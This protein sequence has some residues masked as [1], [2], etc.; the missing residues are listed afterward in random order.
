[1]TSIK[2][3]MLPLFVVVGALLQLGCD[4]PQT[5][6]GQGARIVRFGSGPGLGGQGGNGQTSQ[7]IPIQPYNSNMYAS[8]QAFVSAFM[9]PNSVGTINNSGDVFIIGYIDRNQQGQVNYA[10]SAIRIEIQDSYARSGQDVPISLEIDQLSY[11]V[12]NGN[13][14]QL[15][16]EYQPNNSSASGAN[17]IIIEGEMGQSQFSGLVR[18]SN[19]SSYSSQSNPTSGVL[20]TFQV[21][22]CGFFRCSN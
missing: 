8:V 15:V 17:Q 6:S 4:S 7:W 2:L 19:G 21:A 9:D 12:A 13:S 22:T 1:M 14:V 18:F 20:G 16:F 5:K 10:T 11:A 3:R